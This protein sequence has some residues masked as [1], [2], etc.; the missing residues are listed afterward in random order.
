[1]SQRKRRPRVNRHFRIDDDL[2]PAD[3]SA[4]RA[5]L[6]EPR[7]TN[8]S[9][10]AWLV[11]KGYTTFSESAV[12]RHKRF[13]LERFAHEAQSMERAKQW[14][15]L[16]RDTPSDGG[17]VV[18]GAVVLSEVMLVRE[19]FDVGGRC[20]SD[21]ELDR[22]GE[23]VSRMVKTRVALTKLE[24]GARRQGRVDA[25]AGAAEAKTQEERD[26]ATLKK[27]S[28]ILGEPYR[29]PE[30]RA[31]SKRAWEAFEGRRRQGGGAPSEN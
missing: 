4:Y 26:E 19:L 7:T 27:V 17:D 20:V 29:T 21:E 18:A 9:A 5:Y 14:A 15:A 16:A 28:E 12:A 25:P 30:Q 8:K 10:H 22:F 31:A 24:L 6:V 1:M 23:L 13:Y 2:S 11:A 3:L